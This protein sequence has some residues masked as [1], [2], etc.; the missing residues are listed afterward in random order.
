[1][2]AVAAAGPTLCRCQHAVQSPEVPPQ[3]H[4]VGGAALGDVGRSHLLDERRAQHLLRADLASTQMKLRVA[5]EVLQA[6]RAAACGHV[7]RQLKRTNDFRLSRLV[8]SMGDGKPMG[9]RRAR[10][11]ERV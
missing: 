3:S 6:H 8:L 7:Q 9:H 4:F 2:Q 10:L 1:V 5:Q 11:G